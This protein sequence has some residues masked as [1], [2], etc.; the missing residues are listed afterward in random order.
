MIHSGSGRLGG[1]VSVCKLMWVHVSAWVCACV[2]VCVRVYVCVR[3]RV[4]VYAC[5]C[6]YVW[7]YFDA[8]NPRA[9]AGLYP[10]PPT[11]AHRGLAFW[12]VPRFGL[13][14]QCYRWRGCVGSK[15][16]GSNANS[17]TAAFKCFE[18]ASKR[19]SNASGWRDDENITLPTHICNNAKAAVWAGA[20]SSAFQFSTHT[21][22]HAPKI[23]ICLQFSTRTHTHTH[24]R[25]HIART[26]RKFQFSGATSYIA[27]DPH[28]RLHTWSK[29]PYFPPTG[30]QIRGASCFYHFRATNTLSGGALCL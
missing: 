28:S 20:A 16:I 23:E 11:P 1:C 4:C 19:G 14:Y 10:S 21:H 5:V 26:L 24:A 7:A 9:L 30:M 17:P 29:E 15:R 18:R 25:T 2:H 12:H 27:E 6:A 22:T 3:A 13:S 8:Q